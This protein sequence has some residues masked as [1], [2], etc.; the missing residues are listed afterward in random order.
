[1]LGGQLN[2]L[3]IS[4][5][6]FTA[7]PGSLFTLTTLVCLDL[8]GNKLT[9][10][11]DDIKQLKSL[12]ELVISDNRITEISDGIY[13][14]P[15]LENLFASNN[16][17]QT[18]DPLKICNMKFLSTLNFQ[19]NDLSQVPP[20][21]GRATQIKSLQLEGNGFRLPRHEIL[22][23]GTTAILDYLRSRLPN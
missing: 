7:L 22:A 17:I 20:E 4:L 12:R 1:M 2:E 3:N 13:E 9:S 14:L 5:N 8:R 18:I 21:L 11:P 10:I 19:N 6:A 15:I 16:R 23:K